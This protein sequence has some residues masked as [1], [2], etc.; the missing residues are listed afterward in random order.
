[1]PIYTR[2]GD[3]GDTTL[4]GGKKVPKNNLRVEA[5][6]EVDE[7]N[8][9]LGI[10]IAFSEYEEITNP[11]K[12]MQKD[13]FV[14]GAELASEKP[15]DKIPHMYPQ[16]VADME[17]AM[18]RI[19]SEVGVLRHFILPGGSKLASLLHHGRTVCRR[20][21]RRIV[22]LSENEKV[23]PETIKYINRLSDYLFMLAR[24]ANRKKRV[25]ETLWKGR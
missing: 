7:L 23:N 14:I 18:D 22:S 9:I 20:A 19:E 2:T 21:E 4:F 5:Y 15:N 3:K 16:K 8:S 25:E 10:V 17:K 1:M 12:E 11:L 6:G 13:L 24:M